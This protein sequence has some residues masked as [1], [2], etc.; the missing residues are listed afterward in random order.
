M[1]AANLDATMRDRK[2]EPRPMMSAM[3]PEQL[4]LPA[5]PDELRGDTATSVSTI[6]PRGECAG[7]S[8]AR[9]EAYCRAKV[10]GTFPSIQEQDSWDE[11]FRFYSSATRRIAERVGLR[12]VDVEDCLQDAWTEVFLQLAAG[13][14]NPQ[15]GQL[16]SWIFSLVRNKAVDLRRSARPRTPLAQGDLDL[17][18]SSREL[19][20]AVAYEQKRKY[21]LLHSALDSLF[22]QLSPATFQT[23]YG[24][25]IEEKS[26]AQ[27]ASELGLSRE[28]VRYRRRRAK[29]SLQKL[30]RHW[31]EWAEHAKIMD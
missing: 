12:G 23:L 21:L 2:I 17:I 16:F 25:W 3:N 18:P 24:F 7:E 30:L 22:G 26:C 4:G 9:I 28:Q 10:R 6:E 27:M 11:F 29:L 1:F 5:S 13:G 14:F 15:R 8:L 31:P 19:D 20:P